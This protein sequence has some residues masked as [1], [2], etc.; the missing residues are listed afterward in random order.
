MLGINI[1]DREPKP[2]NFG[3]ECPGNARE[4]LELKIK[5]HFHS[6]YFP[7][8]AKDDKKKITTSMKNK[9]KPTTSVQN[10]DMDDT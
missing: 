6:K 8:F 3:T 7:F 2:H 4:N 5:I 9:L 10:R 1:N